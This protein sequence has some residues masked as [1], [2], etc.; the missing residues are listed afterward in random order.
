M[1]TVEKKSP[2][3]RNFSVG[4]FIVEVPLLSTVRITAAAGADF[5]IFEGEHGTIELGPLR[6]AVGMCRALGLEALV[7]TPCVST[8]WIAR[9]LDSG[10]RGILVPN[11][12]TAGEAAAIVE[13]A[14]FPP[15]GRRGAAFNSSQDDYTAGSIATKIEEANRNIVI[16]CMIE[17]P[18]GVQN[19]EEIVATPGIAGCWFG[20]IDFSIAAG[21]P[22]QL[23]HP[24]VMQAASRVA[25]ACKS[26]LKVAGVMTTSDEH[27]GPYLSMGYDVVAWASD[28]IV[29]RQGL[30][31]GFN[32]CR[33]SLSKVS[34]QRSQQ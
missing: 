22:G 1:T 10:A 18:R 12:E 17:S 31:Q 7:R 8:T 9:A 6:S 26:R 33:E 19:V 11:V 30:M 3:D 34:K 25:D 29:L 13:Q 15:K 4:T 14:Y 16:L 20:Y 32:Q 28:A 27:L 24:D 23:D 21:L 2:G 5:V